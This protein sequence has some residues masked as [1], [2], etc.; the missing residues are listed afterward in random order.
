MRNLGLRVSTTFKM[1]FF[2]TFYGCR[3]ISYLV[4]LFVFS[5]FLVK[6]NLVIKIVVMKL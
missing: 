1:N 5:L 2:E 6:F 4:Y 3:S